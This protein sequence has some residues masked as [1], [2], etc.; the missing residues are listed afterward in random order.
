MKASQAAG[1]VDLNVLPRGMRPAEFSGRAA[2][3][4]AAAVL[5]IAGLVPLSMQAQ[6]LRSDADALERQVGAYESQIGVLQVDLTRARAL[7]VE[8]AEL[9]RESAALVAEREALQG[10]ERSLSEDIV[11]LWGYGFQPAGVRI[12]RVTGAPEGFSVTG[13]APGPLEAIAYARTLATAGRFVS[14]RMASFVPAEGG[15]TFVLEV[16]R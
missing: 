16:E 13:S 9:E 3:L 6:S 12:S 10:G 15:G 5:A 2:I 11:M 14:A 7:I 8:R 1:I 4:A